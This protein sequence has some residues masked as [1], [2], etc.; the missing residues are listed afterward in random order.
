MRK[1]W[2]IVLH[3]HLVSDSTGDTVHSVVRAAISQFEDVKFSE[4]HWPLIRTLEQIDVI[5]DAVK[6]ILKKI[7][8]KFP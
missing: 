1:S 5:L 2:G 8:K 6:K 7:L 4:Y 3:L